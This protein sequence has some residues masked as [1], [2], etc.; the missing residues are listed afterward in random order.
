MGNLG[1]YQL[2]TIA[3]KAVGGPKRLLGIL[4]AGGALLG[5]GGTLSTQQIIKKQKPE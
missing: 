2:I 3:A 4:L 1:W 5:A